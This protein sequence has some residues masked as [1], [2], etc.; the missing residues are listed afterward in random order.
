MR[1]NQEFCSQDNLSVRFSFRVMYT[2]LK[3]CQQDIL[4]IWKREDLVYERRR[5]KCLEHSRKL[6]N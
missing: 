1:E 4:P 3:S 5:V 6:N 2:K